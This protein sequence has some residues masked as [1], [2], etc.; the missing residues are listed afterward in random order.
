[1]ILRL[2]GSYL[3]FGSSNSDIRAGLG[4]P[5]NIIN[6]AGPNLDGAVPSQLFADSERDTAKVEWPGTPVS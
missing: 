5:E 4:N 3:D 2:I 6:L 1:M